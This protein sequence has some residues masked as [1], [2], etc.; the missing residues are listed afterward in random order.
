MVGRQVLD[1]LLSDP[2]YEAVNSIGRRKL[3]IESDKLHQE[4]VDFENL[5]LHA[6]LFDV[7]HVYCCLGTTMKK[8]GS[9]A[10]FEKVDMEY[11][12]KMAAMSAMANVMS[13]SIIT[14]MGSTS[15]SMF[16]YNRVKGDVE[17]ALEETSIPSISIL[18]PSLLLG[19]REERRFG[20]DVAQTAFKLVGGLMAGPL[21]KYKGIEGGQ[22][23]R[24]M[25][26][27]TKESRKG[28]IRYPNDLLLEF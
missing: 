3:E 9:K 27:V 13:F 1:L 10:A 4:I 22:V 5:D 21:K 25:V 24:A 20:E 15:K 18:Q 19:E 11:P 17:A 23:A 12:L 8:A 7:D 16:Y 26:F 6:T 28:L 2:D 14:A